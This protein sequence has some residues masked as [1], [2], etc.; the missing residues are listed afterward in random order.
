M[1][2]YGLYTGIMDKYQAVL[3]KNFRE[4]L[5]AESDVE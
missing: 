1:N 3:A 4:K 5:L 2:D